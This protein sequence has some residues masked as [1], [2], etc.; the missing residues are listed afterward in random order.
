LRAGQP[1]LTEWRTMGSLG[2]R[3]SADLGPLRGWWGAAAAGGAMT[4]IV[5]GAPRWTGALGAGPTLGVIVDVTRRFG[6]SAEAQILALAYR[7]DDQ[8]VVSAAPSV[9]LGASFDF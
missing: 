8:T 5:R 7:R 1:D 4:Q 3:W 2:W 6:L 9:F